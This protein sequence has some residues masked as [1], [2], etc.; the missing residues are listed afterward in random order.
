MAETA[1]ETDN[2]GSDF[3]DKTEKKIY[4]LKYQ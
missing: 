2:T 3:T 4:K 1:D